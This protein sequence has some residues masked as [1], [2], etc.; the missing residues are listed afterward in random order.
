MALWGSRAICND[1]SS[2]G[3][4]MVELERGSTGTKLWKEVK[5]KRVR[6]PDLVC[7]H[8]GQRAESRA[9]TKAEL[10]MSHSATDQERAWD[11]GMIET[12][13]IGF[14]VCEPIDE[15]YWSAGRLQSDA[16]YWHE[17]NWVLWELK[18]R[19]NYFRV[20]AFRAVPPTKTDTKGVTEGSETSISWHAH[21]S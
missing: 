19:I 21:F 11:F 20:G 15:K 17:R 18:G 12:D 3:H 1:L 14:P 6:I 4:Q 5:R 2:H 10:A 8:C 9:K 7:V 16:S 13:L